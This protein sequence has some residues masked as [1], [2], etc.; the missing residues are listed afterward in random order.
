MTEN[1]IRG[2]SSGGGS[3]KASKPKIDPDDL[4]SRQFARVMDLISEGEIEGFA[5]PSKEGLSQ[6]TQAYLNSAKKD[7][8]LDNTPILKSTADSADPSRADFNYQDVDFDFKV[9]TS[10]QTIMDVA[11]ED[12]G[13]SNIISLNNLPV[14]N[15]NGKTSGA[16]T[17]SVTKQIVDPTVDRV[18]ITLNFPRLEKITDEGDQLG[19]KVKLRIQVQY[20][21]GGFETVK[22]DT[23]N[24]RTRDLYQKD[25]NIKLKNIFDA[26]GNRTADVRVLRLTEDSDNQ[27]LVD[28]F[29]WNSYSELKLERETFPDSAYTALRFDSK[30]FGSIP[31]RAFKIRGIKVRIPALSGAAAGTQATYSQAGNIVTVSLSSH[32]FSVG[33]FIVFTPISGGTPGGQYSILSSNFN[34]NSF[35]LFVNEV[36]TVTDNATCRIL[37]TPIVDSQTGRIIYPANYVF[38]G[39][40]GFAVWTTCP[41]FI[42]LDLLVNK[43][44]GFGEHIAPDQSTDAKLYENIDLYSYFNASKFANEL[45]VIGEDANGNDITEPRF[46]CN[47]SIQ[48][49]VNAFTLINSLAGVMRCMP[50]W[51]SGG[52]TLSQDKPVD[53]SYLFNLSNVTESGFVYSGSDLKTRSTVINVSYLNMDIRDIDYE[54]VGDNVTGPSPDQDDIERQ[55]KYGVVVKNIK[56][57]ACTSRTQARRLGKAMLLSQ[58]RETETVTF[59]TSLDAGIICRNG[60]VIQIADPV[61]AGLRR[62]GRV[63][64]VGSTLTSG[65]INQ[66]TIDNQAS[67]GLQTS[68]LGTN[69]RLSVILPDGSTESQPVN[70]WTDGVITISGSFTQAPNPQTVW[71][72]ENETL[73]PQLFR[74]VNIEE[75][76]GINYTI[77]ALSYVPDKYDAIEK[78]EELEDRKITVLSD[79]PQPPEESSV[80]GTERIVVINGKAISKLILSWKPVRGISEYQVNYKLEDNNFTSVRTDSPD[81]EIFNSSAGTYTVEVFSIGPLGLISSTPASATIVAIGKSKPPADLTG[82]SIEP[83]NDTDVRL[84]WDLHPDADVIHGGQIYIRHQKDTSGAATFQN[85]TKLVEAVAGNSTLAV[86]PA[87]E[88]EYVLKARDDTGNFST[89]EISVILDIPEEIQPLDVLTRRE[90]LDNP[91]FQ[92][93]KSSSVEVSEDLG[94]IDLKSTGLFDDI[95]DF[96]QLASLDDFGAI[97]PEGFYDFGGTAGGTV[98]DLGAVYNLQLQ[99][100]IFSDA[101]NPNNVF[102]FIANVDQMNDFDGVQAFDANADLLVRSSLNSSTLSQN[103]T[104]TQV[105]DVI[106]VD[107]NS[108]NY[109][110]GNFVTCD[111]TSG[112]AV[113]DELQIISITNADQFKVRVTNTNN[114]LSSSGNVTCGTDYTPFASFANGRFKGRSYKFRAK[115]TSQNINQDVKITE[116][117]Y[118][119]SFPRRTE[120]STTNIA[121]GAG[122]KV[123]TFEHEFFTGTSTLGG[124]NSSLP[125][126]GITAQNMASGDFFEVTNISGS[127]F[128]VTFKNSSGNAIDRNFGFTAV[129]FGKKG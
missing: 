89:G 40:M 56:A 105:D 111:F 25:Y 9:G 114:V 115:L 10:N 97:S 38:D 8:F 46:S 118:T 121:S 44:Y 104:Y 87:M 123:I 99:R 93:T 12:T 119:A 23:I 41:A 107:I 100:H 96:D 95:I 71:M 122:T 3:K 11:R 20:N 65:A 24:G 129:G 55:S 127:G 18:R 126:I 82:L 70:E 78:D 47:A 74:V 112:N 15:S 1:I 43:R 125:S 117:G 52:I 124:V 37:G 88:G 21:S 66:I 2:Y 7:I 84:R 26:S 34:D 31:Q 73:K 17:G 69:P 91:I 36:Q 102:D 63:K 113:D 27:N 98:L 86:V 4:N 57:F 110:A 94:S 39:T 13:S 28:A 5:S 64:A 109:R 50:I 67:V 30:Q 58:E 19:T 29:F 61:R 90:D 59:T 68:T 106:T 14:T 83:I 48:N 6:D 92:G 116:L 101:F 128:S 49:S 16:E 45:V 75:V 79:P 51:S 77:T 53:P 72:F 81:F 54:T 33:D 62:G 108:H 42:L 103:G 22:D 80:T 35:E 120:Q 76:D 32:G 60:A 85:S